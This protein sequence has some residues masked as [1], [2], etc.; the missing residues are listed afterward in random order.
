M[1]GFLPYNATFMLDVALVSIFLVIP[2]L[3]LGLIQAHKKKYS[4]HAKTMVFLGVL[5]FIVVLAFEID[6]RLQGGIEQILIKS[7]RSLAYT[8]NFQTLIYVHLF[9]A[10]STCI[11]WIYTILSAIKKFGLK[12]PQPGA[13]SKTHKLLARLTILDILGVAVTGMAVYYMAFIKD[14]N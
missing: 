11:L 6:L 9:F 1:S 13:F 5:V 14:I 12:N 7:E 4:Q 10:F 2:I 3:I 8:K